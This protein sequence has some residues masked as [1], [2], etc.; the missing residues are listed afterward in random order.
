[1]EEGGDAYGTPNWFER[2]WTRL[3][4][5]PE[6]PDLVDVW[7]AAGGARGGEKYQ[8]LGIGHN[9]EKWEVAKNC[10][11][12]QSRCYFLCGSGTVQWSDYND[13][14][15]HLGHRRVPMHTMSM[16]E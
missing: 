16:S 14:L 9:G 1:M 3:T 11:L 2:A 13:I 12:T 4:A 15:L 10:H 6:A 8:L 5:G 7:A